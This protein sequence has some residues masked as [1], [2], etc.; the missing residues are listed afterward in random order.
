[1]AKEPAAYVAIIEKIF[2]DH[3]KKGRA[4]FEF[5]REEIADAATALEVTFPKN[6][7][8]VVYT[9]RYRKKPSRQN[10]CHSAK[11]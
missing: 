8:D 4:D 1:M 10:P 7:G 5:D 3:Y 2:F 9:F 11:R 6:L